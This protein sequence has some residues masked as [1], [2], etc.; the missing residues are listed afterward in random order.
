MPAT[1]KTSFTLTPE[2]MAQIRDLAQHWSISSKFGVPKSRVLATCID[3]IWQAEIGEVG[4][5]AKNGK[6]I[7]L[8]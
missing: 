8:E 2:T 1:E 7:P 3:R 5:L 4:R 6:K